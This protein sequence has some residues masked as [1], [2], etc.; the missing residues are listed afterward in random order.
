LL[1]R[2]AT[3]FPNAGGLFKPIQAIQRV[4]TSMQ[5][6]LGDLVDLHHLE[7]LAGPKGVHVSSR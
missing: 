2:K 5:H 6:L 4:T 1:A 7:L 3:A